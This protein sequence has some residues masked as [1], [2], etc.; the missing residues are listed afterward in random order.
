VNNRRTLIASDIA[1]NCLSALE[2]S[3]MKKAMLVWTDIFF[4]EEIGLLSSEYYTA[5]DTVM[6]ALMKSTHPFGLKL[7]ELR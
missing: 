3:P 5:I 2:R 4:F 7:F 1:N 6:R